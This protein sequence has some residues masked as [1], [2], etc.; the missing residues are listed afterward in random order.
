MDEAAVEPASGPRTITIDRRWAIWAAAVTALVILALIATLAFG[1]GD[2]H[3][4][5]A[6]GPGGPG[7]GEVQGGTQGMPAYPS[8]EAAP[9]VSPPMPQGVAPS[10]PA[11]PAPSGPGG[12][13][14]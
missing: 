6:F 2:S 1:S 13:N 3:E 10:T 9:R 5:P 14:R 4:H 8:E 12:S 11:N 7:F